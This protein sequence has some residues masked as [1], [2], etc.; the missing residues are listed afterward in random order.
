MRVIVAMLMVSSVAAWQL[1][2]PTVTTRAG[3]VAGACMAAKKLTPA[4]LKREGEAVVAR[5]QAMQAGTTMV[6]TVPTTAAEDA[7]AFWKS[8]VQA[9]A[10]ARAD[11]SQGAQDGGMTQRRPTGNVAAISA[12]PG[13]QPAGPGAQAPRFATSATDMVNPG[14]A[15]GERGV[16]EADSRGLRRPDWSQRAQNGDS[17]GGD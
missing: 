9:R 10:A 12:G 2:A 14:R 3:R 11:W 5:R 8:V 17:L 6:P 1:L 4:E 16:P 15:P 13:A 7:R